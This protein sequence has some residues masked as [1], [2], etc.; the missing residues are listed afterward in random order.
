MDTD[1][2]A[3]PFGH[4][5]LMFS[6]QESETSPIQ[7]KDSVGYYSQ[8]ST[9]T[10]PIIKGLK[11]A[12][13]FNID[14]QDGHGVLKRESMRYLDGKGLNGISF[15][16][17][18]QQ[19]E[20]ISTQYQDMLKTQEQVINELNIELVSKGLKANGYNRFIAEKIKAV[21]EGRP[22][23]LKPFHI[24]MELTIRGFDS[25]NSFT[26]KDL[27]L[28]L[29]T[30]NNIIPTDIRNQIISN[31]ALTAFPRFSSIELPPIR[32]IS[33]GEFVKTSS[34]NSGTVF[35]NHEWGNNDLFWATP[36]H[37]V[38]TRV[39]EHRL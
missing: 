11:Q 7:V 26:C 14:L 32:L 31:R 13:G 2:G 1:A 12:L 9:T 22:P 34:K 39:T 21:A 30:H 20:S 18:A 33:T 16:V 8:P 19:F 10:N 25:S 23:R 5:C 15:S 38:N 17:T 36:I 27:S 24:T 28:E 4:S 29:L 35:Y 6:S 3:N 37:T